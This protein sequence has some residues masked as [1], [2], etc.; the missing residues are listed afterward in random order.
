MG[1]TRGLT[2]ENGEVTDTYLYDAYG[3]GV[4]EVGDTEN[5]YRFAG[6]QFDGTLG[7]YYLRQRY[8]D[9]SSGRFTRRDTYEG[10]LGDPVSLHKYIYANSNPVSYIDPS[11]YRSL[12]Y[13]LT[14]IAIAS[15][16]ADQFISNPFD[17][18]AVD[19]L[20]TALPAQGG[21]INLSTIFDLVKEA[22][23]FRKI[24]KISKWRNVAVFEYVD[25][26]NWEN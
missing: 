13:Y 15:F 7:Q 2:D 25:K 19:P 8:Y 4:S 6:E 21:Q 24:K 5:D 23:D 3:E 14:I 9:P 17:V 26:K 11:G 20:D 10:R 16:I 1:S 18:L 22:I 12:G